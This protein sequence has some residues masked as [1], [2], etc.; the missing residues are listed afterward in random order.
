MT[1]TTTTITGQQIS[2]MIIDQLMQQRP[3]RG[4]WNNAVNEYA[5]E[6]AQNLEYLDG[7]EDFL[8]WNIVERAL[9]NGAQNWREYSEGGCALIYNADIAERL[10][11]PSELRKIT[12]KDGSL[13]DLDFIGIQARALY[14]AAKRVRRII[15]SM[16]PQIEEMIN[17]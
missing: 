6:I 11:T 4:H 14:Q 16:R 5:T 10:C 3:M 12:H 7:P 9:L 17:N 1:T 8:S 13:R 2:G 15:N